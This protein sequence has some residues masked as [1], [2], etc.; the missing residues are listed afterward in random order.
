M[1]Q[2]I[3]EISIMFSKLNFQN[4]RQVTLIKWKEEI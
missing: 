3:S 2:S 4:N 1:G